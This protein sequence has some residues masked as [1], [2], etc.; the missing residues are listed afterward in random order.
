M[1]VIFFLLYQVHNIFHLRTYAIQM[2]IAHSAMD[3][4]SHWDYLL[5]FTFIV[6]VPLY[7]CVFLLQVIFQYNSDSIPNSFQCKVCVC[8]WVNVLH[9]GAVDSGSAT[10]PIPRAKS[11]HIDAGKYFLPFELACRSKCPRIVNASLDCLQ[12]C[13]CSLWALFLCG[14]MLVLMLASY[15]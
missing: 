15:N 9:S 8:G 7:W 13:L 6:Y 2:N 14:D 12:V 10:L 1:F 4:E 11:G 3:Y 5:C